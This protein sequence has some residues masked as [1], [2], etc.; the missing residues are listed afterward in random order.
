M[1]QTVAKA[2]SPDDETGLQ[3]F[4]CFRKGSRNSSPQ[5]RRRVATEV[6]D[7]LAAT[8]GNR[9]DGWRVRADSMQ[10]G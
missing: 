1:I 2:L 3:D 10:R 7:G 9:I 4:G 6:C 5:R 8:P